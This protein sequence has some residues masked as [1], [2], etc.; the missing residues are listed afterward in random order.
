MPV[1][2]TNLD[3]ND[4]RRHAINR[5]K[6]NECNGMHKSNSGTY[7]AVP[8]A[9]LPRCEMKE[10]LSALMGDLF[11]IDSGAHPKAVA[12]PMKDNK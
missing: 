8:S 10:S 4:A 3:F 9:T 7:P 12:D 6:S 1:L 11:E 5:Y 2:F